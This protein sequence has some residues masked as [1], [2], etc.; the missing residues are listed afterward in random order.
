[1]LSKCAANHWRDLLTHVGMTKIHREFELRATL[2]AA[3]IADVER[4]EPEVLMSFSARRKPRLFQPHS[5]Q[6][7]QLCIETTYEDLRTTLAAVNAERDGAARHQCKTMWV[8]E[9]VT[10]DVQVAITAPWLQPFEGEQA[11]V[12]ARDAGGQL[13]SADFDA[14]SVRRHD[15][16]GGVWPLDGD[17]AIVR[18]V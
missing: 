11:V 10:G 2:P 13:R 16:D 18:A 4:I 7:T 17:D 15:E 9:A 1:M 14:A 6:C 5:E 12:F 3:A 8:I